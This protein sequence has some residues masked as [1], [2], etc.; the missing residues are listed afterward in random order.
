MKRKTELDAPPRQSTAVLTVEVQSNNCHI[1]GKIQAIYDIAASLL[2]NVAPSKCQKRNLMDAAT[3]LLVLYSNV[4]RKIPDLVPDG[5]S[6]YSLSRIHV[7]KNHEVC[8]EKYC[9][10]PRE[11][12]R[13]RI[14][15]IGG[16]TVPLPDNRTQYTTHYVPANE[17][18]P[19]N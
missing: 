8:I 17:K 15:L 2:D 1:G 5:T 18:Y 9:S 19:K 16:I 3:N 11:N 12:L 6:R 14:F 13:T 7:E 10:A 4:E